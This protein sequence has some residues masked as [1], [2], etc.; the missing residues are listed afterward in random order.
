MK[1]ALLT[2]V[3]L[4]H[5]AFADPAFDSGLISYNKGDWEQAIEQWSSITQGGQTSA[6]IEFN[7]GNAYFRMENIERSILHYERALKLKPNDNDIRKN[8][9]LA[10]RGIVDQIASVPKLGILRGIESLRDALPIESTKSFLFLFNA[11][12]AIA[13]GVAFYSSGSLSETSRRAAIVFGSLTCL[14]LFWFV[15]R[16]AALT[17]TSAIVIAEKCD[18][19][20]SPTDNSTQLFSLHAGTKVL[21]GETL[22]NWIEIQLADGR[23]GWIPSEDVENI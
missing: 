11:L 3:I 13:I 4:C 21:T 10:N 12:L 8:L 15:W 19:F 14:M 23:K 9:A 22:A 2:V 18:I 5:T 1:I 7:L 6:E 20:S 16:S 17:Q